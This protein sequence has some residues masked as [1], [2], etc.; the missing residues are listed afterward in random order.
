MARFNLGS[1]VVLLTEH[2]CPALEA[3]E[4]DTPV[5]LGQV[6]SAKALV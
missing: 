5:K 4:S 1:T 6:L 3:I 2:P